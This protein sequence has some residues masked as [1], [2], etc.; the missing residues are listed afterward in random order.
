MIRVF[1]TSPTVATVLCIASTSYIFGIVLPND[2]RDVS[3]GHELVIYLGVVKLLRD[4]L[5]VKSTLSEIKADS[6][7]VLGH[8]IFEL[9]VSEKIAGIR[10]DGVVAC[11]SLWGLEKRAYHTTC[12]G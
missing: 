6:G 4:V 8:Q 3:Q 11:R 9:G 10:S 7:F 5:R 12:L 2:I 1:G